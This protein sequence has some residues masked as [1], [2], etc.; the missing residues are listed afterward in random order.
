MN[1]S[2]LSLG[3]TSK[4]DEKGQPETYWRPTRDVPHELRLVVQPGG[5]G[6]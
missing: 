1:N 2:I 6:H 5:S 3:E 4:E